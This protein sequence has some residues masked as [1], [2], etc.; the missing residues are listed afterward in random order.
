MTAPPRFR[1]CAVCDSS[2]V[3]GSSLAGLGLGCWATQNRLS[4]IV[5]TACCGCRSDAKNPCTPERKRKKTRFASLAGLGSIPATCTRPAAPLTR[6]RD[7][8][9]R[10]VHPRVDVGGLGDAS[11]SMP[12][13]VSSSIPYRLPTW[14]TWQATL[15]TARSDLF[16]FIYLARCPLCLV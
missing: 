3:V 14:A 9:A 8:L 12:T 4:F 1:V 5:V 10:G 13:I 16:L 15:Y 7:L 2:I 6:G 11:A